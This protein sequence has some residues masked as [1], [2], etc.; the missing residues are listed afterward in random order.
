MNQVIFKLK[1]RPCKHEV[2]CVVL[3]IDILPLV[4]EVEIAEQPKSLTINEPSIWSNIPNLKD[5][6]FSLILYSEKWSSSTKQKIY[7]R[8]CPKFL[9]LYATTLLSHTPNWNWSIH[10]KA[11]KLWQKFGQLDRWTRWFKY[12]TNLLNRDIISL[13]VR[14]HTLTLIESISFSIKGVRCVEAPDLIYKSKSTFPVHVLELCTHFYPWTPYIY[15]WPQST[16][17]QIILT[18]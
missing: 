17:F 14:L 12:T 4:Q 2:S 16:T 6:I 10:K 1:Q 15:H 7:I 5:T 18:P 3:H 8:W 11:R 9:T 13:T